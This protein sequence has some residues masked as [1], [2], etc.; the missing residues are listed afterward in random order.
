MN[1]NETLRNGQTYTLR[2]KN[3]VEH[4]YENFVFPGSDAISLRLGEDEFGAPAVTI[5]PY[6]L[7]LIIEEQNAH[8]KEIVRLAFEEGARSVTKVN[9]EMGSGVL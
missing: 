6:F 8:I 3:G 5:S 7:E 9:E 4:E 2:D 1:T